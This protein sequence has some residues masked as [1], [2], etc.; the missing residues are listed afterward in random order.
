M[1]NYILP[2]LF[3]FVLTFLLTLL[4]L[5]LFPKWGMVDRPQKYGL[6][7]APVP[8]YG[9]S[10]IVTGFVLSVLLF[11][12]VTPQLIGLIV[13]GLLLAVISFLDDMYGLSPFLR[14][15]VQILA[16]LILVISGIGIT[17]ISNPLGEPFFLDRYKIDILYGISVFGT[18]FTIIWVVAIVN[19]MNF[20]DGVN[21]LSSG[22]AVIAAFALFLLSIR[23]GIHYDV[24]SQEIVATISIILFAC[25]FA[26]W[27]FEFHPAKILMGDTGSIFLGFVL[28][29]LAI[30]SGGK[31]ATAF[32]V[33]GFPVLDAFWSIFRRILAR[34]SPFKGDLM[35]LHHKLLAAGLSERKTLIL[36]YILCALFGG[37]AVYLESLQKLYAIIVMA[38]LMFILGGFATRKSRKV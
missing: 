4:A 32:L 8:Y 31:V 37:I 17:S 25:A 19:T 27:I 30:F 12:P 38:I 24:A 10:V 5:K 20:L 33:M 3:A 14:L 13:G 18:L 28:A 34:K 15:G 22:V 7:R 29:T 21:G 2:A 26:F 1:E 36:I 11:V 16:A 9:G 35:H 6:K 23:P